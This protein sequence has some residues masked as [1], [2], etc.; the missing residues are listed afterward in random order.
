MAR[1]IAVIGKSSRLHCLAKSLRGSSKLPEVYLLS[2]VASP[3]LSADAEV[4]VGRSDD[5]EEV[6]RFVEK[7][8]PDLV[9]IGPEEPLEKGIV[10]MLVAQ[11]IA[12]VG[13]T[14]RLA[15]L[16]TSKVFTRNLLD[17]HTIPG[18][19]DYRIFDSTSGIAEYLRRLGEF[20]IKPDGLTGGK[21]V[22][23]SNEHL[24]S[25]PEALDY[26]KQ[27]LEEGRP[28]IVE[29]K[30]DGEE[31]SY[32]SFFDGKHIAHTIPVQDHKRALV[33]DTGPNTGGMGSYSCENHLLPFLS[34]QD[35]REAGDIN[36]KVGAALLAETGEEYKGI[37]YGGF[38]LTKKGLRVIEYNARFGDPEAM[39][40]LPLMEVDFLDV[41]D[42]IVQ[43]TLDRVAVTF[44]KMAT[45]CKYI[46]PDEYPQKPK[47]EGR[48]DV[49]QL[50]AM[51]RSDDRLKIYYGAVSGLDYSLTGS[52]A[53]A[54]LGIGATIAEAEEVAEKAASSVS[55]PVRHRSDI[56]KPGLLQKRVDHMAS[57][58]AQRG[59]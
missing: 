6:G 5:R 52:R 4:T 38:M 45:V 59:G 17:K 8:R 7:V 19:P 22:K 49:S 12:C 50:E 14:K 35:V 18:N 25:I 1:K 58:T 30:L 2:D 28:V 44:R 21:G 55:G 9:V 51:E 24:R 3:G 32:Q 27:L 47:C 39:N 20:V 54:V 33:G 15:Q 42:A 23:V 26:C 10:D 34:E 48:V 16:E 36:Q 37:L 40:V 31:F 57:L 41:C 56:G 53:I 43:G 13:P 46:V 29:E 11:G